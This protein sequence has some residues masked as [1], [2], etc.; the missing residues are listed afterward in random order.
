M[1]L[2]NSVII[3]MVGGSDNHSASLGTKQ[4]SLYGVQQGELGEIMSYQVEVLHRYGELWRRR[5]RS[6]IAGLSDPDSEPASDVGCR[7]TRDRINSIPADNGTSGH[8]Y[9]VI[10]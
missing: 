8:E 3:L 6:C 10:T 7:S 2:I 1:G 9:R 4:T 5:R